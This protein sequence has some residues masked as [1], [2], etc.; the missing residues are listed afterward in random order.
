MS[1]QYEESILALRAARREVVPQGAASRAAWAAMTQKAVVEL[2]DGVTADQGLS[3]QPEG[4]A[5]AAVGSLGRKDGG[6]ES[7][8]DI[9]IIHDGGKHPELPRGMSGLAD[10]LWYPIWDSHVELDHSVRSLGE[11][12]GVAKADLKAGLGLL[13]VRYLAGDPTIVEKATSSILQDWRSAA[14]LR[15]DSVAEDQVDRRR[16]FGRLSYLIEG[17]LKEAAGG[18][19]D[20]LLIKALVASWL[21]ER[22]ALTYEPAYE[23]LL[24]VRDALTSV[25]RRHNNV[26]RLEFQDDVASLLG[27]TGETDQD[28]ADEL[29]AAVSDAARTIRAAYADTLRR[30]RRNASTSSNRWLQPRIIRGR[31]VPPHLTEVAPGVGERSGELV[32]TAASNPAD[33]RVLLATAKAAASKD[34]PI[35]PATLLHM[36]ESGAGRALGEGGAWPEWARADFETIL[37]AGHPQVSVWESLDIA[38]IMTELIPAWSL[39]RNLP[40]RSAI[41]RHTVD[42]HQIEATANLPDLRSASGATLA[43]L[44]P[45][46]RSTLLLATFFH[47]MGKRPG[48]PDH[49]ER[50]AHMMEG[51]LA[52]MGYSESI[53]TDAARL[54]HYHLLLGALAT[55]ADPEDPDTINLISDAVAGQKELLDCLHLLTQ[56]D[57]SSC[58]PEAWDIWKA[59]LVDQLVGRTYYSLT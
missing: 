28:P 17:D 31:V 55:S 38:G 58:K 15:F 10:A 29:L 3:P 33:P 47:D 1:A 18:M 42:R 19:R 59:T 37:S 14:R 8:L 49:S 51:I 34:L 52:P 23:F 56:A 7:D 41:H 2:W 35:R 20:A 16:Q 9:L 24:D 12:R 13:D 54:V 40:Q 25:T 53:I 44:T 21:A 22:P 46:R 6:P 32:L 45:A 26:L 39:V 30:A 4:I 50:G 48:V 11:C 5:L 36:W 57:A 27:F 43:S